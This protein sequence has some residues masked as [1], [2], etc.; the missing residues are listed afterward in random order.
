MKRF[1]VMLLVLLVLV[2]TTVVFADNPYNQ[3]LTDDGIIVWGATGDQYSNTKMDR[4]AWTPDTNGEGQT[5]QLNVEA[6]AYIP[7]YLKM[8]FNGNDGISILES[9]GPK[10]NGTN[11]AQA[12]GSIPSPEAGMYHM[13]FDNEIGGFV[14]GNWAS[15]GHGRNAEIAPGPNVYIQACDVFKVQLF[16]ND[17]FKYDVISAPLVQGAN[18]LNL[19]IGTSTTIDGAYDAQVF[20]A[21]KTINIGQG[22]PCT[23]LQYF[24]RFRVPYAANVVHGSYSGN[25]TFKAYTI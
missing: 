16:S 24:H 9:F 5:A 1:N 8:E 23:S 18:K 3:H 7:C 6:L 15:L 21:A 19:E 12:V 25:V 20:D 13:I 4:K 17:D 2:A 11:I 14:D 10:K 22:A